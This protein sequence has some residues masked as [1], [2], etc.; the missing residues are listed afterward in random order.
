[1]HHDDDPEFSVPLLRIDTS[2]VKVIL[3]ATIQRDGSLVLDGQDLGPLVHEMWDDGDYEYWLTVQAADLDRVGAALLEE[4]YPQPA[5]RRAWLAER[6]ATDRDGLAPRRVLT[7]LQE[8]FE[9]GRFSSDSDFRAWLTE[10]GISTEFS[11]YA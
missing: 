7:L 8:L 9:A 10:R 6:G 3:D 5:D 2:R 4:R 1:M 11:S